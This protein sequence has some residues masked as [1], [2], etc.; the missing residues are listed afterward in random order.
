[1]SNHGGGR[2]RR[3]GSVQRT[4]SLPRSAYGDDE[5]G[6]GDVVQEKAFVKHTCGHNVLWELL[7]TVLEPA[8]WFKSTSVHP[9]PPCG[10]ETGFVP[11]GYEWPDHFLLAGVG[12]AP[13]AAAVF[14]L[15][16]PNFKAQGGEC[17]P[18]RPQRRS[19]SCFLSLFA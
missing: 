5:L 2:V 19:R 14:Y 13:A 8:D 3:L 18:R 7:P 4:L 1:M 15:C 9:C 10:G 12:V 16:L 17:R 6:A 11:E